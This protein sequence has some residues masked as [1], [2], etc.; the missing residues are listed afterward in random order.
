[1]T[2][3]EGLGGLR[4]GEQTSKAERPSYVVY[5]PLLRLRLDVDCLGIAATMLHF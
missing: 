5:I 3:L 4:L 2:W 1:M